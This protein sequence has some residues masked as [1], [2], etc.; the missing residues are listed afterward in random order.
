M[1]LDESPESISNNQVLLNQIEASPIQGS[2]SNT[3]SLIKHLNNFIGIQHRQFVIFLNLESSKTKSLQLLQ[4]LNKNHLYLFL[5][6]KVYIS[7]K[8]RI[9]HLKSYCQS[10]SFVND[11]VESPLS[12]QEFKKISES[13]NKCIMTAI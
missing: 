6:I 7:T 11:I 2:F 1:F 12:F 13:A 3:H 8:D 5:N 10:F 4:G 9:S